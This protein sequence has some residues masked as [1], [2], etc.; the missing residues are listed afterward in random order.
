MA[1]R[2]VRMSVYKVF[3]FA[4]ACSKTSI[5]LLSKDKY[6]A[7]RSRLHLGQIDFQVGFF[8]NFSL[9]NFQGYYSKCISYGLLYPTYLVFEGGDL[10]PVAPIYFYYRIQFEFC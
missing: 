8:P 1:R 10:T 2:V 9:Y 7:V 3:Y 5:F 6:A 4:T